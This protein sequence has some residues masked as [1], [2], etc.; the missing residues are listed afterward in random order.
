MSI[1]LLKEQFP[2]AELYAL[3]ISEE[4]LNKI[5]QFCKQIFLCDCQDMKPIK[6]NSFDFVYS[7][8]VLEHLFYPEKFLKEVHR[9]LKPRGI[10]ILSTPNLAAWFNRF[11]LLFGYQPSNYTVSAEFKDVGLPKFIKKKNLWDHPR[12]FSANALKDLLR[13]TDFELVK[14]EIINMTYKNQPYKKIRWLAG[15][16]IPKNW[17]ECIMVKA[18]K[19]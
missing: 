7:V 5:K 16:I 8:Q 12:V 2:N 1:P 3:N 6:D 13:E 11:L 15:K 19:V 10:L 4:E 9:V 14:M 18:R 17:K